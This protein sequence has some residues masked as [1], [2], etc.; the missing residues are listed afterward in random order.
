MCVNVLVPGSSRDT[1]SACPAS[2]RV[3]HLDMD[4]NQDIIILDFLTY[5]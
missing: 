4:G 5:T 1:Q 2:G 3:V